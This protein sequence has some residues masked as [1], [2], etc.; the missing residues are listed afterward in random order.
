MIKNTDDIEIDIEQLAEYIEQYRETD[1]R[2]KQR[3]IENQ[4]LAETVW[5]TRSET[6]TDELTLSHRDAEIIRAAVS[7]DALE[8]KRLLR[9][10]FLDN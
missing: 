3:E 9:S 6:Q 4:V 8:A 7:D 1:D 2:E 10:G 5:K